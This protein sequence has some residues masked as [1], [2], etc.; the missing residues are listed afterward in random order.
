MRLL[1]NE[2][3]NTLGDPQNEGRGPCSRFDDNDTLRSPGESLA[4]SEPMGP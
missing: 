2:A 1:S 3:K 4:K